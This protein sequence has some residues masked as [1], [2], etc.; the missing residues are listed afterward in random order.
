M[1]EFVRFEILINPY[2]RSK[3]K[4]IDDVVTYLS[5]VLVKKGMFPLEL[6]A[7]E[8]GEYYAKE[9]LC[10][11]DPNELLDVFFKYH[12]MKGW[13]SEKCNV[14]LTPDTGYRLRWQDEEGNVFDPVCIKLYNYIEHLSCN[15]VAAQSGLVLLMDNPITHTEK[16]GLI[17]FTD[18]FF[19]VASPAEIKKYGDVYSHVRTYP[20][21]AR[22]GKPYQKQKP[23]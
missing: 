5:T 22:T 6:C 10:Y 11:L 13:L 9:E 4:F 16:K 19:H 12:A 17:K 1:S 15:G 8:D 20:W 18:A 21:C 23:F 2:H 7:D 3:A 14:S